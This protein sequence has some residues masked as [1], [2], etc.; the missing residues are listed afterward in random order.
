MRVSESLI[1]L[2][3]ALI[4]V[5]IAFRHRAWD[6]RK[7]Q[8]DHVSDSAKEVSDIAKVVR[9]IPTIPIFVVR[10]V[11]TFIHVGHIPEEKRAVGGA[12]AAEQ[13]S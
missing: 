6:T 11:R 9:T 7:S 4:A 2:T 3:G 13:I 12:T 5:V 10:P 1:A 8:V